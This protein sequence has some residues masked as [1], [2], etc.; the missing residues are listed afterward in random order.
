MKRLGLI[1][2]LLLLVAAAQAQV[3]Q[4][5]GTVYERSAHYGMAGVTVHS[6]FGNGTVTDSTG[7]YSIRLEKTDSIYFSYQGKTTMHIPVK[8]IPVNE[9][10]NMSLNVEIKVLPTVT[11]VQRNYYTDSVNTRKDYAKAFNY[12]TNYLGQGS[13][14]IGLD[15]DVLTNAKKAKRMENFRTR[16]EEDEHEKYISHRFNKELVEKITQL[17]SPAID[18]FMV[19]YRPT[20]EQLHDFES[21]YEYYEYIRDSGNYFAE[22]W[23]IE[24]PDAPPARAEEAKK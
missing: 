22:R 13:G 7:Y 5:Q 24:H 15:F 2:I 9:P 1:M 3:Q 20:Y 4:V 8:D 19:Q 14:G 11:I 6:S 10:F 17:Q 12:N 16:L 21:E 18:T 23:K